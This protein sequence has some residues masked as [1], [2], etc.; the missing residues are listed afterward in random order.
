[1]GCLY[2]KN[3]SRESRRYMFLVDEAMGGATVNN[4]SNMNK[5]KHSQQILS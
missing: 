4:V 2:R 5:C 1:M 3:N